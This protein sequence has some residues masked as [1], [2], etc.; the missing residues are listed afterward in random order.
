MLTEVEVYGL[1]GCPNCLRLTPVV[2]KNA[3][4]RFRVKCFRCGMSTA[5]TSKTQALIDWGRLC[6]DELYKK[7]NLLLDEIGQRDNK[8]TELE[9]RLK[10]YE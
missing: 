8:I 1:P 9:R 5:W 2:E 4:G 10:Y 6:V 3:G 7:R